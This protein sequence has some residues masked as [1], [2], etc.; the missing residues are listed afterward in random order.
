MSVERS[1]AEQTFRRWLSRGMAG[2]SFAIR[3]SRDPTH[4][5]AF[6]TDLRPV[7]MI[8]ADAITTHVVEA[9]RREQVPVALFPAARTDRDTT[10]LVT[11]LSQS[12][13]WDLK[14]RA[15]SNDDRPGV[16]EVELRFTT[17]DDATAY[18]MGFVPSGHMPVTRRAPYLAL[19]IWPG[20]RR[21]PFFKKGKAGI[22]TMAHAPHGLDEATHESAWQ[23]SEEATAELLGTLHNK[24]TELRRVAF[25]LPSNC[26]APG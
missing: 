2:C 17:T 16:V 14:V 20:P 4:R 12:D 15:V 26:L 13:R 7:G 19:A 24:A 3:L 11:C 1:L 22:T 18:A 6:F 10:A 9:A 5:L 8:Q 25:C 23:A 21:N